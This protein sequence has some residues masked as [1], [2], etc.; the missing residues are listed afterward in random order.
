MIVAQSLGWGIVSLVVGV[1]LGVGLV[2]NIWRERRLIDRDREWAIDDAAR[3]LREP[4]DDTSTTEVQGVR[5][6]QE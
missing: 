6:V 3:A 5:E 2:V 4:E 1:A